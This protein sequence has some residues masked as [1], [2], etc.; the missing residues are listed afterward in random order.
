MNKTH[1]FD[2]YLRKDKLPH[3]WCPGCGNGIVVNALL[4]AIANI[5]IDQDKIVVVA[6][7]GCSS[8]A[9]GYMNFCGMHTNH[10][11]ALAY[12]SGVKMFNP[13]LKVIVVTGDGDCTSIGGNH[14]IHA[15]RRNIGITTVVFNNL[16][17]G[18]TGGQYSP[19]TPLES[20]TKTSLYGNME[21][22]FD[23]CA[24]AAA[25]GAT[26]VARSTTFHVK[27]LTTQLEKALKHNGF[28]VVEAICDCPT[29]YGRIN[30]L[31]DAPA[32]LMDKK[33]HSISIKQAQTMSPEEIQDK[34]VIGEFA[35]RIDIPEYTERYGKLVDKVRQ[36]DANG[37]M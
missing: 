18:M 22:T 2:Q 19:T 5:G 8:R 14:F 32:M 12:A 10:G 9:N 13:D 27:M 1:I 4:H 17:Y 7:I 21:P 37:G 11:R 24:L 35:N 34:I 23:I 28:S 3:I 31:G 25:S 30:K 29:L 15:C 36:A 20:K 6:G 26:Y 33:E 16:N